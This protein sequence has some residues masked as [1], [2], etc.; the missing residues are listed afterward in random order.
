MAKKRGYPDRRGMGADSDYIAE[1]F[2]PSEQFKAQQMAMA[3]ELIGG[4]MNPEQVT[5][6]FPVPVE[7]PS[8]EEQEDE[9]PK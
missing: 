4:G 5:S 1:L 8:V 3:Q 6:M 9:E 2:I 7:L